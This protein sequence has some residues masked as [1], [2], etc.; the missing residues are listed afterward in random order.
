MKAQTDR[1]EGRANRK[2]NRETDTRVSK[3][4][5]MQPNGLTD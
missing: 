1:N 2:T 4:T 5:A 3:P